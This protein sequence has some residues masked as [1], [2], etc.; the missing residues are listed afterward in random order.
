MLE[1]PG[2]AWREQPWPLSDALQGSPQAAAWR[3]A[4]MAS[5]GFTHFE[6]RMDVYVAR[7]PAI[8]APG[9][10]YRVA[11]LS[12]AALPTA[13]RRCADLAISAF[14]KPVINTLPA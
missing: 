14:L 3:H 12:E 10:L 1:L 9:L 11:T 2:L 4:G 5:H 7:V 8:V 6:L 13:M